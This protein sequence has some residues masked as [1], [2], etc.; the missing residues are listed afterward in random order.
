MSAADAGRV[1]VLGGSGFIG[2]HVARHLRRLGVACD[3]P[4]RDDESIF[5]RPLGHVIYAIGLTADFRAR[6]LETVEAH[7]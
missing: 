3:T 2:S 1:T 6:P 7:V 4:A 5:S